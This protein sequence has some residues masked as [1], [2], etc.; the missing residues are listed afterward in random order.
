MD[1]PAG[2]A[3]DSRRTGA[4]ASLHRRQQRTEL[5][6]AAIRALSGQP[7]LHFRGRLLYRGN[8]REP[9][10]APHLHP[11][12]DGGL[13]A[14]RGAADGMALRL[15]HSDRALH[16]HH[17]PQPATARLVFEMLEQFRV[18]SLA[19][20]A[21]PGVRTNLGRRFRQWSR[22][23]EAS[24]LTG[25]AQGILL[26]AVAQI[27]RARVTAEPMAAAVEDL[28]EATRFELAP[29][30]GTHLAA[31]RRQRFSQ[32]GYAHPARAIAE[33]IAARC[34]VLEA[35]M[36]RPARS[37]A[38]PPAFALLFEHEHDDD[39]VPTAAYGRS[40][41]LEA[42]AGGYRVFTKAY[43]KQRNAAGLARPELLRG[44]RQQLDEN[45][46]GQRINVHRLGRA[47]GALL[48][49]RVRDGWDSGAE[50]GQIDGGR[51]SLL[52]ASP[53]ERRVFRSERTA[54]RTEATVTFLIDCSGSMK[55]HSLAAAVLV[56]VFARALELAGARSEILGFTTGAWH[57]GRARKEWLRAGRPAHPGR[58]NEVRHLVFKD[59]DTSWRRARPG[60]AGLL[61]RDL[62]RE[63]ID[64]EAVEWACSRLADAGQDSGA[65]RRL[66][67]VLSDGSPTDGATALANDDQYLDHHLQ[68][69]VAGHEAAGSTEIYGLG[70]GLDLGPYYRQSTSLD[71]SR[72]TTNAV[73]DQVLTLLA[74]RR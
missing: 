32:S 56:D 7:G 26:F 17:C 63:G 30:I 41:A 11:N 72:G 64:G 74:A 37:A 55:E 31:L 20:D 15:Q 40:G 12:D 1:A 43:D 29:H 22:E 10:P 4:A 5:C 52:V 45:I 46:A 54:A 61:K 51:L 53:V 71:L 6:A 35:R 38:R 66:L 73:V 8:L 68:N 42:S 19:D 36:T 16:E 24:T 59:V 13:A 28:I 23:F 44:Y 27:G 50:E 9:M 69:V 57:G 65:E 60:I 49:T 39:G 21:M 47:L 58:L 67:L 14:L 48:S 33:E 18:E 25:T 62:F 70:V 3:E 2:P 34:D